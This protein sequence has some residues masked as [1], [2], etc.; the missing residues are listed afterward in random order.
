MLLQ[1]MHDRMKD[2]A[3]TKTLSK[4]QVSADADD[5]IVPQTG[6]NVPDKDSLF[7]EEG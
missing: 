3:K 2:D 6:R 1:E 5:E 4:K 7:H